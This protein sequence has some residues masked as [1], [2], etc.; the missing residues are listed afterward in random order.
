MCSGLMPNL[1]GVM[2]SVSHAMHAHTPFAVIVGRLPNC[3]LNGGCWLLISLSPLSLWLCSGALVAELARLKEE[4]AL[5]LQSMAED[6]ACRLAA[7]EANRQAAVDG[8]LE[9]TRILH[10]EHARTIAEAVDSAGGH[11]RTLQWNCILPCPACCNVRLTRLC[12]MR[13]FTPLAWLVV[14]ALVP[15]VCPGVG[16][17]R[18]CVRH[19]SWMGCVPTRSRPRLPSPSPGASCGPLTAVE[20]AQ[21]ELETAHAVA[22]DKLNQRWERKVERIRQDKDQELNAAVSALATQVCVWLIPYCG[23]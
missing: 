17:Q 4:H 14:P 13:H 5:Q 18:L 22:L 15:R 16:L 19:R 10:E 8:F 6:A 7:A 3:S 21:E 11:C 2:I 1:D 9:E 20:A 12:S 23:G